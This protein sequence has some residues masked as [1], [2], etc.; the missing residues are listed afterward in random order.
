[1]ATHDINFVNELCD[2]LI[3]LLEDGDFIVGNTQ[4]ILTEEN[5]SA[6]FNS[7]ISKFSKGDSAIFYPG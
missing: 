3:L 5:L 7:K 1:M 6:A 4:D 2:K